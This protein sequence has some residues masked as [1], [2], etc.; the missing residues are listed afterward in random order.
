MGAC[1]NRPIR[2]FVTQL[3]L[4]YQFTQPAS[5][6][7]ERRPRSVSFFDHRCVLLSD[8]IHLVYSRVYFGEANSL[9]SG[10]CCDCLH[11]AI[12]RD[13]VALDESGGAKVGHGSGGIV[14][15]RAE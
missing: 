13:D 1:S 12:D 15:L 2:F 5:L 11:V 9:F 6:V 14:R 10:G 4:T 7:R 3:E 8:L